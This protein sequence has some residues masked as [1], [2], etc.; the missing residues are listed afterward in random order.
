MFDTKQ[1]LKTVQIQ[2][3]LVSRPFSAIA[4]NLHSTE[5]EVIETL[6]S[7]KQQGILRSIAGIFNAKKLSYQSN[8]VA[9]VVPHNNIE[10]AVRVINPLPGVS[11]NYLRDGDYN[12]WFT[13]ALP[14][15]ENFSDYVEEL[16]KQ[17]GALRYNIFKA[18]TMVKLSAR[19]DPDDVISDPQ[20]TVKNPDESITIDNTVKQAIRVLQ[21]DLPLVAEAFGAIVTEKKIPIDVDKVL[22]TGEKLL[23]AGVMRSYRAVVR[24]HAVGF[25]ANAMTVW[26]ADNDRLSDLLREFSTEP[27]ISHLYVREAFP[28]PWEY[29]VFAMVH[30]KS[31]EELSA[32][33][34]KLHS[35]AKVDYRSYRSLQEFKKER[36][37]YFEH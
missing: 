10:E 31:Q 37:K 24:H 15:E 29:P 36:V 21:Q 12:I 13:L 14:Q 20:F 35:I 18:T 26:K 25:V 23:A 32:I 33:I 2:V 5:D 3:P 4:F 34:Q 22:A 27:S 6:A 9:F 19:F 28:N 1:L 16:A 8:L 7:L 30:A 17:A 11:H